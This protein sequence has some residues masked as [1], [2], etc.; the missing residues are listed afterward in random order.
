MRKMLF[1]LLSALLCLSSC[2]LDLLNGKTPGFDSPFTPE[3]EIPFS[4][5]ATKRIIATSAYYEDRIVVRWDAVTGAETYTL[6]RA[7]FSS[8][9]TADNI[10]SAQWRRLESVEGTRYEDS[11]SSLRAGYYYAYRVTANSG[12]ETGATS[13]FC[14]G[15]LLSPPQSVDATKG[16]DTAR[17]TISWTQMPG[18]DRYI[19]HSSS[20]SDT[21]AIGTEIAEV[22]QINA[23]D[24]KGLVNSYSYTVPQASL[25]STLYFAVTAVGE[26]GQESEEMSPATSGYTRVIGAAASPEVQTAT[27]GDSTSEIRISWLRDSSSTEADP[28]S[29][30][31][32]RSSEGSSEQVIYPQYQGQELSYDSASDTYYIVD[33]SN[34]RENVEYTY[35]IVALN[36]IGMS[37]ATSVTA[38]ILSAPQS[39]SFSA[40]DRSYRLNVTLPVGAEDDENQWTYQMIVTKE[41]GSSETVSLSQDGLTN[42]VVPITAETASDN[43]YQDEARKVEI[44]TVNGS[45]MSS[46]SVTASIRGIPDVPQLSVSSNRRSVFSANDNGVYPVE[47]TMANNSGYA[48]YDYVITRTNV[49]DNDEGGSQS[50]ITTDSTYYDNQDTEV[51][52]VYSYSAIARDQ[53]GRSSSSSSAAEGYG[54]ITGEAFIE[55]FEDFVLKPWENGTLNPEYVSGSKSSIWNY[56]RQSGMGSLG[57][58][59]VTGSALLGSP[60]SSLTGLTGTIHYNASYNGNFGG[61]VSFNYTPYMTE[62]VK[63]FDRD[64]YLAQSS[65]YSMDVSLSGSGSVSGGPF[66]LAGMYPGTVDFGGLSVSNNTFIGRYSLTQTHENGVVVSYEVRL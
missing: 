14:Y 57:S 45:L 62:A 28:V 11:D 56:I 35:S 32:T 13:T 60:D 50:F 37:P 41:D 25:G 44:R 24:P 36:S 6:E 38:Y 7:E 31:V 34:I 12:L 18:V 49:G 63:Y 22:D 4:G 27:R 23:A 10:D 48:P 26:N 51:G 53:L 33:T 20:S 19:I 55:I 29:Y 59:T 39:V 8:L 46:S 43:E 40:E 61:L 21:I 5:E 30:T 58:A 17:I 42:Y 16:T 2:N 3:V 9:P 64:F 15:C 47:I 1:F 66:T 65:S 52:Q 54:A